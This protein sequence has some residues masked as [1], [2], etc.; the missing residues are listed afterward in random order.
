MVRS[1]SFEKGVESPRQTPKAH[2]QRSTDRTYIVPVR[3]DRQRLTEA[4]SCQPTESRQS[5]D[6]PTVVNRQSPTEPDRAQASSRQVPCSRSVRL[7]QAVNRQTDRPTDRQ[8]DRLHQRTT[9]RQRVYR[10]EMDGP[11]T[12]GLCQTTLVTS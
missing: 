2:R 6:S 11:V 3:I 9:D 12:V 10:F 4:D 1:A 7:C 5:P 8:T